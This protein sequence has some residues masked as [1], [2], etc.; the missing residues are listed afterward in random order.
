MKSNY[1]FFNPFLSLS[2]PLLLVLFTLGGFR[3]A[4]GQC[5]PIS[6]LPCGNV[7]VSLPVSLPFS[8]SVAGTIL[9]KNGAGTGFTMVDACSGTRLSQDGAPSNSSVPGYDASKLTLSGGRLQLMT[10]KGIAYLTNNNQINTLGVKVDSRG[11]LRI[12]TT[13]VN[14]FNGTSSQQAGLWFGLSDK[15]FLKLAVS[16][17]KVE[18]RREINDV[19]STLAGTSNPDQRITAAIANL[20]TLTVHLRLVIN[21]AS[22]TAE[23]FYS[24]D[25]VNYLSAGAAY[26]TK[27][28]SISGM[29]LT[30]STA[31]AGIYASHRN[32][33]TSVNYSFE[34]FNVTQPTAGNTAPVFSPASYSFPVA[35][36]GAVGTAIGQLSASDADGDALTYSIIAGNTNGA[37][38]INTSS[39]AISVAKFLNYHTQSSYAL[40]VRVSDARGLSDDANVLINVT[41]GTIKPAI[42]AINWSTAASQPYPVSEAQGEVV[43]GKLYIF[44]GFDSQKPCCTP[45]SRAY[46]FDPVANTWTA[47]ASLPAM[48]G[49]SYGGVTHAGFTTDGTDIYF[50]GGYT[51]NSTGTAQIFGTKE[52]WKFIV[53]ENR[54]VRLPDLPIAISAGQ[55]EY[56]NGKLYHIA[57]TNTS[58]TLD[59]GN[60]YV[61][62]LENLA[63]GW[64]TLAELP[65]PR[66]H[67][68]ST[69]YEGKIYFIGGQAGHDQNLITKKDVHRY[70]P[71]TNSWS[72]LAD[73][74]VP[75]GAN[76]RGHISSA[77]TIYGTQ[78]IVMGGEIAHGSPTNMVSAYAPSNNTWANLTPL[79]ANRLSGVAAS[80][81][82][83][84]YFTGGSSTSTT[85][86]GTPGGTQQV[87]SFTL[88]N[89]DTEQP[90]QTLTNG[91]TLN[92][93]TL[94]SRNLNIRANTLPATVGSVV[95]NLSGTQ[96]KTVTESYAPYALFGDNTGMDYNAWTPAVGSYTLMATPY[97]A[98]GGTGTAGTSLTV[99]FSV[100]DQPATT[101]TTTQTQSI[102]Q[103]K[104]FP[105]PILGDAVRIEVL[106]LNP[107]EG[108]KLWLMDMSGRILEVKQITTDEKGNASTIL[109]TTKRLQ[110]GFYLLQIQ[111]RVGQIQRRLMIVN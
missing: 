1:T 96:S 81:G 100:V 62:D 80:L 82:S 64:S 29:G 25:G 56:L 49:T 18:L 68:G 24:T 3:S 17:N 5:P 30:A 15:T 88:I 22:N 54:Y 87:S 61:L 23:G 108:V 14:P 95:F 106:N 20:N 46:V 103:V 40:T 109:S 6:T 19:S 10:S 111:I 34:D 47:I 35:D 93:A 37:F 12:E 97:T 85:Y 28:L 42:S 99:N 26:S 7:Q 53:A 11:P 9:D 51:S 31:Y 86:K 98:S 104:V 65:N 91:S 90:I 60:H 48:N 71:T 78:I 79:P 73:L 107:Q 27:T 94:P 4:Y 16:A 57:G 39:S 13:L 105:N 45:T 69:V 38:A 102:S 110:A 55:L 63:A 33:T 76:G 89:A 44:G 92:L 66:Q 101:S 74:P 43:N 52:V 72:K 50:A 36:N 21:P 32:A 77:V 8:S 59:L 58:R 84:L 2:L 75:S 70:D 41:A 67:A 83:N